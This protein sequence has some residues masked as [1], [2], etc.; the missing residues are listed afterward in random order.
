MKKIIFGFVILTLFFVNALTCKAVCNDNVL[1]AAKD[2]KVEAISMTDD[3]IY[4]VIKISNL[5]PDIYVTVYE[6]DNETTTTYTY[7]DSENGVIEI[8][9]WYIYEKVYY[10]VNVYSNVE[11][12]TGESL[13]EIRVNTKK[14]NERYGYVSC[15]ENPDY[16]KCDPFYEPPAGEEQTD[17][18]FYEEIQEYNKKQN[19]SFWDKVSNIIKE[20]YLYA[21]IPILVVTIIYVIIIWIYKSKRGDT[22]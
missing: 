4:Y 3:L 16:E 1:L 14:F 12:C 17:E 20:Y 6:D 10:T 5:T 7:D 11:G 15:E 13:N 2:V 22:E 19:T 8:E 18:E 9:Q 21:L